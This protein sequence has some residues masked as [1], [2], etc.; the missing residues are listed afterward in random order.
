MKAD[1]NS[2][3]AVKV[4]F[5][6]YDV[7]NDGRIGPRELLNLAFDV[8]Y[9]IDLE[10]AEKVVKI[11]DK[12]DDGE[13][14]FKEFYRWWRKHDKFEAL[15][16][17]N[18]ET[19]KTLQDLA[20]HFKNYDTEGNGQLT[21]DQWKLFWEE[22]VCPFRGTVYGDDQ[23]TKAIEYFYAYGDTSGDGEIQWDEF[24]TLMERIGFIGDGIETSEESSWGS[25]EYSYSSGSGENAQEEY[26]SSDE[27]DLG[28][29]AALYSFI[30]ARLTTREKSIKK[31]KHDPTFPSDFA[32]EIIEKVKSM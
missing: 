3:V 29:Y 17:E 19:H 14:E 27:L 25:G 9:P 6:Q 4:L 31:G 32:Q 12:D 21:L 8:G 28:E 2:R 10:H 22:Q 23:E 16:N 1:K 5:Q 18:D 15:I 11:I 30:V 20:D 26:S 24:T 13:I 7:D